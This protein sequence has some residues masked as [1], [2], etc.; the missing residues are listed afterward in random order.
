MVPVSHCDGD[1]LSQHPG[2]FGASHTHWPDTHVSPAGHT[3]P[4]Q[5][6][7]PPVQSGDAPEHTAHAAWLPH[8][9]DV[10]PGTQREGDAFEQQP[11][12]FGASHTHWAV[13]P[14]PTHLSPE[15]HAGPVPHWHCP[16]E[17]HPFAE[18]SVHERQ[19]APMT[20]HADGDDGVSHV[21]PE[22][23]PFAHE[24]LSHLHAP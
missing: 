16:P 15:L 11:V 9:I 1:L 13:A 10:L 20:P 6:Q 12:Q 21:L 23:Q 14:V 7:L 17:L 19:A 18:G 8:C 4:L 5:V 3:V 24:T 22:Q 2:Q